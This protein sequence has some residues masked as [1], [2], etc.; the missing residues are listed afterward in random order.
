MPL[1]RQGNCPMDLRQQ[2]SKL[3][4]PT[5]GCV[6]PSAQRASLSPTGNCLNGYVYNPYSSRCIRANGATARRITAR[7]N[8][9]VRV[10]TVN[11]VNAINAA[12]PRQ[13]EPL[14]QTLFS[15]QQVREMKE[16]MAPKFK[17]HLRAMTVPPRNPRSTRSPVVAR[18]KAASSTKRGVA[19][20]AAATRRDADSARRVAAALARMK[21]VKNASKK[22]ANN[23][24]AKKKANNNFR[25]TLNQLPNLSPPRTSKNFF[26]QVRDL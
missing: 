25:Q 20:K 17:Q 3:L 19:R 11:T 26:S 8:S 23:A 18:R 5:W 21:A 7:V 24:A 12:F 9:N 1:S 6:V 22:K 2:K 10:N 14:R 15:A 16:K 4:K 13:E